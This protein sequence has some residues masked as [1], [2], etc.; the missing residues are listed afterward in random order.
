MENLNNESSEEVKVVPEAPQDDGSTSSGTA[1]TK[2]KTLT[3]I[4][5]VASVLVAAA[6]VLVVLLSGS[7]PQKYMKAGEYGKAYSAAETDD[8]KADVLAEY[9]VA[10]VSD[11]AIEQ[12]AEPESFELLDAWAKG[13]TQIVLH[14]A[15]NTTTG[16]RV[17][18]YWYYEHYNGEWRYEYYTSLEKDPSASAFLNTIL[19]DKVVPIVTTDGYELSAESID[20]INGLFKDG[21]LDKIAFGD[22]SSEK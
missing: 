16:K 6:V 19:V 9:M 5:S 20:R 4:I 2:K 22:K 14:T 21:L 7:S 12:M 13:M 1:S 18:G 10:L 11:M 8:E 17:D 15:G 3:I